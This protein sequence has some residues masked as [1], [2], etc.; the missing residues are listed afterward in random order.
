M[1]KQKLRCLITDCINNLSSAQLKSEDEAIISQILTSKQWQ[2]AKSVFCYIP[3]D[4]EVNTYPLIENALANNKI[5]SVPYI[6]QDG[7]M[8]AKQ[9]NKLAGLQP[10][11]YGIP[12]PSVNN[13]S[14]LP[15]EIDLIIVPGIAYEKESLLRLG[16]GGGFYDRFL[17][18]TKA[19]R[20]APVRKC[21][22]VEEGIIAKNEYDLHM[23]VLITANEDM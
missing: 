17:A 16:R 15:Q 12:T 6:L 2:M 4:K 20:L 8:E 1:D 19:L 9:I 7:V 3:I 22:L 13:K 21:Q 14:I 23:D 18:K 5:V 11:R 10:D